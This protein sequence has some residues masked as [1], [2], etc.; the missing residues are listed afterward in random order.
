MSY[1]GWK[2]LFLI[3]S[4]QIKVALMVHSGRKM[5]PFNLQHTV[6]VF[7]SNHGP[8]QLFRLARA[9]TILPSKKNVLT[10]QPLP[11]DIK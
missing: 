6:F 1:S 3:A 5:E 10:V 7:F 9:K 4:F 2:L 8:C 11:S